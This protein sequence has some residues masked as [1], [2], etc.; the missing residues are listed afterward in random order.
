LAVKTLHG[1][2]HAAS[3][4]FTVFGISVELISH[5]HHGGQHFQSLHSWIG[6][7]SIVIF[8][9]EFLF[10]FVCFLSP[11]NTAK[12]IHLSIHKF[13]GCLCFVSSIA[14][15][16]IG[17]NESARFNE[18]YQKMTGEGILINVIG[19]LIL[20]FGSLV[21]CVVTFGIK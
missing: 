9:F 12:A 4:I 10:G 13:F 1:L 11:K 15:S 7:I 16:L 14:A 19:V 3:I 6:F 18:S 2:L 21:T 8:S 5:S 20:V 17:L